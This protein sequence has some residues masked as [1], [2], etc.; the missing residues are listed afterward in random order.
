MGDAPVKKIIKEE[1]LTVNN[2]PGI[3]VSDIIS[4]TI[5]K[6]IEGLAPLL[7]RGGASPEVV[8]RS[9][10]S[11]RRDVIREINTDFERLVNAN[12]RFLEKLANTPKSEQVVVRIPKVY[13]KYLGGSLPVGLNGSIIYIPADNRPYLVPKSM[14]AIIENTIAYEDEKIDFMERTGNSD[15]AEIPQGQL[16]I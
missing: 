6:T 2:V 12:K 10:E 16:K 14:K 11:V 3:D 15:V 13:A 4:Q 5:Q 9:G 7:N 1:D 8:Q